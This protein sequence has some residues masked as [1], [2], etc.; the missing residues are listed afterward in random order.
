M[1]TATWS[2]TN[3]CT[4]DAEFRALVAELQ[5]KWAAVGLVQASDTG[6]INSSTATRPASTNTT[7]GYEVWKFNDT[8]QATAPVY[9]KIEYGVGAT[10]SI[11]SLWI[12]VGTG[13]NGSGTLTGTALSTRRQC[14][15]NSSTGFNTAAVYTSYL[16]YKDGSLGLVHKYGAYGSVGNIGSQNGFYM[17]RTCDGTGAWTATGLAFYTRQQTGNPPSDKAAVQALR[18]AST[19][20]AYAVSTGSYCLVPHLQTAQ[21]NGDNPVYLHWMP[22]PDMVPVLGICTHVTSHYPLGTFTAT[23]IGSTA[24]TYFTVGNTFW[25]GYAADNATTQYSMAMLWE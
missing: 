14:T 8:L 20:N 25:M 13:S 5:A 23:L 2:T 18:F 6:Q 7:A 19:A 3:S 21:I 4:T 24:R 12:T 16:C 17:C 9:I 11:F 22:V 10:T 1:T 15:S